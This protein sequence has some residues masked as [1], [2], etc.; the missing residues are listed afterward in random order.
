L[1]KS[2]IPALQPLVADGE[3]NARVEARATSSAQAGAK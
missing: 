1:L 2:L 3:Q